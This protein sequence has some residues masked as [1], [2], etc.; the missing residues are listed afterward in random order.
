MFKHQ[1]FKTISIIPQSL[2]QNRPMADGCGC[3]SEFLQVTVGSS[4]PVILRPSGQV[5]FIFLGRGKFL[6]LKESLKSLSSNPRSYS[7][8]RL[9]VYY[10][11][12]VGQRLGIWK[13]VNG[14]QQTCTLIDNRNRPIVGWSIF[15]FWQIGW[16]T[17]VYHLPYIAYQSICAGHADGAMFENFFDQ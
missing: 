9:T 16:R 4:S 6:Q 12:G 2:F 14:G 7:N 5:I 11:L 15:R 3:K 1:N 8:H 10:L 17:T 13:F